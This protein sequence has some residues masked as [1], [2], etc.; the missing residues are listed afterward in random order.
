VTDVP[1]GTTHFDLLVIGGDAV[2]VRGGHRG[3]PRLT[4]IVAE[5]GRLR[6]QTAGKAALGGATAWSGGRMCAPP[7]LP[8]LHNDGD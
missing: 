7:N 4:V 5:K 1:P 6:S 3:L 8:E 2:T